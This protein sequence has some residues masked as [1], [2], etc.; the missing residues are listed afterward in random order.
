MGN[1]TAL[2][3]DNS[4]ASAGHRATTY[5]W[6]QVLP[7]GGEPFLELIDLDTPLGFPDELFKNG[8]NYYEKSGPA[9]HGDCI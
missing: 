9:G 8:Y 4:G 5:S 3:E 6:D 2:C 1:L 7:V